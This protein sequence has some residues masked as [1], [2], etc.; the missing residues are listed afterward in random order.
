[1][2]AQSNQYA[3]SGNV[4]HPCPC[5]VPPN[6]GQLRTSRKNRPAGMVQLSKRGQGKLPDSIIMELTEMSHQGCITALSC[7]ASRA[8]CAPPPG[9]SFRGRAVFLHTPWQIVH[10]GLFDVIDINKT[11]PPSTLRL[12]Y[13]G[14]HPNRCPIGSMAG[15]KVKPPDQ[16]GQREKNCA[17][18]ET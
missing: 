18:G 11:A 8:H 6:G 5:S 13:P 2:P 4:C 17:P 12:L 3:L 9:G 1:M 10:L 14:F 16:H 15:R 7:E